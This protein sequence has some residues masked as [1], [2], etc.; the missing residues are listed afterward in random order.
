[1]QLVKAIVRQR[2]VLRCRW[3]WATVWTLERDLA[4]LLRLLDAGQ[5]GL[6]LAL[7]AICEYAEDHGEEDGDWSEPS[8]VIGAG[9]TG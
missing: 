1:M 3:W 8:V 9:N 6:A 4:S 7:P 5:I 2:W